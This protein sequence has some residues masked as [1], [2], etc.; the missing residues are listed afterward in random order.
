MD[1]IYLIKEQSK[2]SGF[3]CVI[4]IAILENNVG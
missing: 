4:E 2:M 3:H 1:K